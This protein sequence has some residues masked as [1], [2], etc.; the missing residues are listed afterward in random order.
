MVKIWNGVPSIGM[1][2]E[3]IVDLFEV[4]QYKPR[5]IDHSYSKQSL[6][7]PYVLVD[8]HLQTTSKNKGEQK[9]RCRN[10]PV[11]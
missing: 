7:R 2:K 8:F 5:P 4:Y 3:G 11:C 1:D 6:I 9:D 10:Q